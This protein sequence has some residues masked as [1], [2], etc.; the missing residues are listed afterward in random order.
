MQ[1][2]IASLSAALLALTTLGA[3][4]APLRLAR[5]DSPTVLAQHLLDAPDPGQRGSFRVRTLYYG[6]GTDKR[7]AEFRDSVTLRTATVDGSKLAD[8]PGPA[9][10]D[11]AKYWGF[12]FKKMPV[13]G[14]VWYPEGDGPFPLVLIVHGNHNMREFSDP[15]YGYLGELLAS[16]GFILASVDENFLNGAIGRE[17]DA[18]GWMLLQHLRQWRRFNDSTGSP[19][20]GKIDLQRIALMGHSRGGEAVAVAAAFNRLK[21]YPD[22]ATVRFDF[23]FDIRSLVAIAPVDGQYRPADKPTPVENVNY[24]L[25]HGS[26]DGDVSTFSGLPQYER[27]R[28]TDGRPRFKAAIWVYRAN[29]GQWNTVWGNKDNGPRS[30][31]FLDLR[32]LLPPQDQRRFAEVTLTAFLEATLR[33]RREYLPL[34]RDHRVAAGWLPKTMYVT[35]F[36]ESDFRSAADFEEDVDVTTG[37]V[38]GVTLAGDSLASWKEAV[39]PFRSRNSNMAHNAVWLGWNNR[40]AGDDT[41]RLGRP[42]AFA[43]SLGDSLR[44]AW[45]IDRGST[46]VF[47]L[48]PTDAKPGP[49]AAPRDTSKA[50]ADSATRRPPPRRPPPR[51][52]A[53]PDTTA[54][55][56]SLEVV[57]AAGTAARVPLSRYGAVRRPLESYI[58]RRSGRDKLRFASLSELVLQTYSVPLADFAAAAPALDPDRIA[59]VRFVF[60]RTPV[61][62][63]VL[64]N[65]GFSRMSADFLI[66]APGN[67]R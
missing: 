14:R 47:S 51:R 55:D 45:R 53:G 56:L 1:P 50:G 40:I 43:I 32:G 30:G 31:R 21:H 15:G 66:T 42:A 17:N 11:R 19:F 28:F 26:H 41:T 33:D 35:R 36:Q 8:V 48:A 20:A 67:G 4:V 61:G 29:H 27:I 57:D 10:K 13:N 54:F 44:S 18:R 6:S 58:Y 23:G 46:L 12:D 65:I 64:D 25:I 59:T 60:D 3:C 24:L 52:P 22:D 63:I 34:F 5:D 2:R 37:S 49:R 62:T 38:G 7:R 9:G 39:I 16:R